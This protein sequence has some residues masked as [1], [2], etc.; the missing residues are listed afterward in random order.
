MSDTQAYGRTDAELASLPLGLAEGALADKVAII[1]G[2]GTGIGRATAHWFARLGA[3]LVLCGRDPAK[4]ESAGAALG[5]YGGEVVCHALTI[6]DPDAVAR[7]FDVAWDRFGTLD[8]LVN[9]AGGQFPLA[10]ID[11]SP[12]GWAAVIDTNLSGTWYMMQAAARKWR[13]AGRGGAVVN[14]VAVV[15][16]GMPGIAHT[17]AARAGVIG[18]ARTLAIEWA[19]LGVRIN[20]VAPGVIST[21]GMNVY[22]PEA[23]AAFA[24]SNLMKRFGEVEDVANAI[25]FLAADTGRFMTGEVLTVDGGNQLW[26]DQWAIPRP[27]WFGETP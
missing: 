15:G 11:F 9:N 24:G 2:A 6:R 12:K 17:A 20:C 3:K 19:P 27:D 22:A 16:R 8:V 4:L 26:G 5:R 18:L 13:E 10:A 14:V 23:R 21:E 1:S 7:L 25:A